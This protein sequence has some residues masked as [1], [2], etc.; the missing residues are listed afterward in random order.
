MTFT[1]IIQN[2]SGDYKLRTTDGR[3]VLG[4]SNVFLAADDLSS[5]NPA[6]KADI[7]AGNVTVVPFVPTTLQEI[8]N[9]KIDQINK[10]TDDLILGGFAHPDNAEY[11][12]GLV[13]HDQTNFS[14]LYIKK[15]DG[16]DLTGQFFR[17]KRLVSAVWVSQ[18]YVFVDNTDFTRCFDKG[19]AV[20]QVC[21]LTGTQLKDA[22]LAAADEAAVDAVVD[23]R[24]W[25][26]MDASAQASL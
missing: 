18:N 10:S 6:Y 8:K 22:V 12:F 26:D 5:I 15:L 25:T 14:G 16:R 7:D 23:S 17:S 24:T 3:Y 21:V 1:K 19:A 20:I 2:A 9:L 13:S 4:M 11:K